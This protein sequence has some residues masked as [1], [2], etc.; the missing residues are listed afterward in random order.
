M[1]D[2]LLRDEPDLGDLVAGCG[3][4][5]HFRE[6]LES[7]EAR[8]R[9]ANFCQK[10]LVCRSCA[11]R[12]AGKMVAAYAAKVEAI[13][14]SQPQPHF[15][16]MVTLTVKNGDDLGERLAH[17]KA[18]W[19][20]M[21]A[22]ARKGKSTSSTNC[23]IEWN[24]VLGS[25][26]AIEITKRKTGWHPHVHAFVL[27]SDYIDHSA[28]KEE[29]SR[30]TGDSFVVGVT[31]CHNGIVP[32]LIETLKYCSKLTEL[33]PED[34]LHVWRTAKGSRFTDP[35]GCLRGVPEPDIRQDDA[36]GLTGAY[37]D[38]MALWCSSRSAYDLRPVLPPTLPESPNEFE[39]VLAA[40]LRKGAINAEELSVLHAAS[41]DPGRRE[42]FLQLFRVAIPTPTPTAP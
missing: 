7:G 27:L 20:R 35:Q 30:F 15:P 31:K 16:A 34:V 29:W 19:S 18:S 22:A 33:E 9:N 23:R 1:V 39:R 28:L 37:R 6:W 41:S 4:W 12:R 26:R 25:I 14:S 38:F 42:R 2:L 36:D 21:I 40:I 17:L 11:A 5:L 24:K 32:G 13:S 10:F 8:L 3:S